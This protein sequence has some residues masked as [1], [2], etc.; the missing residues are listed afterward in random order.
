VALVFLAINQAA[1]N[2]AWVLSM[3]GVSPW[4]NRLDLLIKPRGIRLRY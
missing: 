1:A 4:A 2:S 3:V